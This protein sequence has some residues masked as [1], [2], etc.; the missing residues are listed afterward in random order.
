LEKKY[1][2]VWSS[3]ANGFKFEGIILWLKKQQKKN[4][5]K[6]TVDGT[7]YLINELSEIAKEQIENLN[8]VDIQLLQKQNE[9]AVS[10]TARIAYTNALKKDLENK[11]K[12]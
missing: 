4:D 12:A 8:F 10:D 2:G 5:E 3:A 9:L 7:D 6:I 1:T 11:E